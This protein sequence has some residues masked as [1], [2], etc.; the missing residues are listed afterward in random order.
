MP[1]KTLHVVPLS[2]PSVTESVTDNQRI[3]QRFR[4]STNA[5]M[6][7]IAMQSIQPKIMSSSSGLLAGPIHQ[8]NDTARGLLTRRIA[9]DRF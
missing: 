9:L 4:S 6:I 5:T 1:N 2:T 7:A 8:V 3:R